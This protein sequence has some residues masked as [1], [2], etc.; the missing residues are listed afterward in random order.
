VA[1]SSVIEI[2]FPGLQSQSLLV[3]MTYTNPTAD[4]LET[5]ILDLNRQLLNAI[6]KSDYSTYASL[7]RPKITY[8]LLGRHGAPGRGYILPRTPL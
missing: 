1:L 5:I 7:A 2:S 8:F 6:A 4:E 3:M